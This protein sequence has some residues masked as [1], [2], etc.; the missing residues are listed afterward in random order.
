MHDIRMDDALAGVT[1][2]KALAVMSTPERACMDF[3]N[4]TKETCPKHKTK[5]RG[6][7]HQLS[8]VK[9]TSRTGQIV[10]VS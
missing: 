9:P 4:V 6:V 8:Y 1:S 3:H 2:G 10:G 5:L 7:V